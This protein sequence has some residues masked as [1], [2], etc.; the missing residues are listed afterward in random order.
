MPILE[1]VEVRVV[2]GSELSQGETRYEALQEW[3][4]QHMRGGK[5]VSTYVEAET[6]KAFRILIKP[7]IPYIPKDSHAAHDYNTRTRAKARELGEET[8]KPGFFRTDEDFEDID[9]EILT[10]NSPSTVQDPL[11]HT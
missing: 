6:G 11:I 10:P 4:T 2:V 7:H 1:Q 5:K 8:D 9:D 3:G